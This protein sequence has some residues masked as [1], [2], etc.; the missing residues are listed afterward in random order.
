MTS[1]TSEDDDFLPGPEGEVQ[2]LLPGYW[3]DPETGAWC[4]LP[5]P[6][7]PD[8][9]QRLAEHSLGPLLIRWAENRLSDEE[10]DEFG[11]GLIDYQTGA[12]WRFTPGQKRFL[13]LWYHYNENGRFYYRSGIKRGAKG[14]GKDPIAAAHGDIE[15]CGP[16]QL[17]WTQEKGWHGVPHRMPL[18]QVASNSEA[19]SKDT[20]RIANA[21]W[22]R[23]A[24]AW[25]GLDCGETRTILKGRG[26]FEV[27]TASE[28]SSEGD[29]ATF[30]ILNESQHM[31]QSS[32]GHKITE[33][34]RRNVGK[35][36]EAIQ[37]RLV[38]YTNAHQM[39]SDSTSERSFVGWQQQT[40]GQYRNLKKDILYD[41]IEADPNLSIYK[42]ADLELA[43][44]QAYSDAPWSDHERLF[45][46]VRDPRTS[47]AEAIRFYLNG[48]AARED[49]WIDPRNWDALARPDIVLAE[50]E[51]IAM[52]LDCS[53]SSD[54]TGLVAV[55]I[56]DGH[57]I[58]LGVWQAP[59]GGRGKH[60]LAPREEVD[61]KVREAFD[62][63]KVMWFGVDPS[64]A[65]DDE[66]EA[67][68]WATP[69][70]RWHRDFHRRLPLWATPG[71]TIGHSVKF[72]MRMS[73]RGARERLQAFTAMAEQCAQWIDE[74]HS[75]TH[76]GDSALRLHVHQARKRG[77]EWGSSL[78]KESR[79]SKK[80]VD[81]A[82]CMVGAQLGRRL[83]LNNPKIRTGTS[84][85]TSRREA[86]VL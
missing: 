54:A 82:V 52:F 12:E 4:S 15:L 58:T 20:L 69:I 80:H 23:E 18:V 6:T 66:T 78:G 5:W 46:E 51:R 67:L 3:V 79:D 11:P 62:R 40:S 72:D 75:I 43:I 21:M 44:K 8:E 16:S 26:R 7:D 77:N 71:A 49:A 36:P 65:T 38:E 73:Q 74:D 10:F 35:S 55:R 86:V 24:R 70:D 19:Q 63:Y 50:K 1:E 56:S 14:T 81:L 34:A 68:Y 22:S 31:T 33:V 25:H 64:P 76:D 30:I 60:W 32:G 42:K 59:K 27:L 84:G 47:A 28:A 13:I 17:V 85:R 83:V 9:K 45:D 41:S 29:P 48:L 37:A 39:G 57:V 53:K 2:E 61:A